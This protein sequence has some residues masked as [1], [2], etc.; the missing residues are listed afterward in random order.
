V[1]MII[2]PIK[3]EGSNLLTVLK[4]QLLVSHNQAE[5]KERLEGCYN[6]GR[7][8][9][10]KTI[11]AENRNYPHGTWVCSNAYNASTWKWRKICVL[12]LLTEFPWNLISKRLT[13]TAQTLDCRLTRYL[14]LKTNLYVNDMECKM[15]QRKETIINRKWDSKH[16]HL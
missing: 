5:I 7:I 10:S 3:E 9:L 15:S 8:W 2:T 12:K 11:K 14:P 6:F 16:D 1:K 4:G 13:T